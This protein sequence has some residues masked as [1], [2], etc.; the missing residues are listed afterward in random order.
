M[1]KTL[2]PTAIM[3]LKEALCSVYWYKSDLRGFLNL[4]LSNKELLS[5]LD[6]ET[7]K[8][9]IA[10]DLVDTMVADPNKHL[11]DLTK[12][13]FELCK[14]N[15]FHH[16]QQL[17]DGTSKVEK[18]RSAVKQLKQLVDPHQELNKE[19]DEIAMRQQLAAEKLR[20][21]QAVRQRLEEVKKKYLALVSS[22]NPP[23]SWI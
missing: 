20:Q 6:W 18:A 22:S 3:A 13:C 17:D 19:Q 5:K 15:D 16:L 9:Q 10:S 12:I 11:G 8:R 21:S 7:Y 1:A 23:K 2:S 14:M 4:C